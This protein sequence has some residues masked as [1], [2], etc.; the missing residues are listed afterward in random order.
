MFN[1]LSLKVKMILSFVGV[2]GL[3]AAQGMLNYQTTSDISDRFKEVVEVN[4]ARLNM[5]SKFTSV[6]AMAFAE[7]GIAGLNAD[8]QE[9]VKHL[10]TVSQLE[11]QL[12]ELD[13]EYRSSPFVDGEEKIYHEF[14]GAWRNWFEAFHK[15]RD[16]GKNSKT[17][18]DNKQFREVIVSSL[19]NKNDELRKVT[20]NL[21]SFHSHLA[22]KAE[23]AGLEE[24]RMARN[25]GILVIAFGMVSAVAIGFAFASFL[26]RRLSD[27]TNKIENSANSSRITGDDTTSAVRKLSENAKTAAS[28]LQ[29][30]VASLEEITSMVRTNTD[31][32]KEA[33]GLSQKSKDSAETGEKEIARLIESMTKIA[34]GSKKI[35]EIINVIDD[36][37]FQTNLLALNAAVEAARAGEQGKG[38]AVVAEAVRNLAQRSAVAARD[39]NS[40]IKENVANSQDGAKVAES[41]SVALAEIVLNVKK[42]SDLNNEI[43]LASQEQ[44]TG[45]EQIS[46]AMNQ[47]DSLTQST[48]ASAEEL[49]VSAES[50]QEQAK[51]FVSLAGNLKT[52]TFGQGA[53]ESDFSSNDRSLQVVQYSVEKK[54]HQERPGTQKKSVSNNTQLIS[55]TPVAPA[56][57]FNLKIPKFMDFKNLVKAES[58]PHSAEDSKIFKSDSVKQETKK[59]DKAA[60][61]KP[62]S[63]GQAK[64]TSKSHKSSAE[65]VSKMDAEKSP[66]KP[67][68]KFD[69]KFKKKDELKTET[70][71]EPKVLAPENVIPFETKKKPVSDLEAILPMEGDDPTRKVGSI[72]GF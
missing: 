70:Q 52:V 20:E 8:G 59:S 5:I 41:S 46:K 63:L 50:I 23:L 15:V 30:T 26:S 53:M 19:F 31:H 11:V 69:L 24:V 60:T 66:A 32:A 17:E 18:A 54:S 47:L 4:V 12:T 27:I 45:I 61:K 14:I 62:S 67:A 43:S 36:I 48:A 21:K 71:S 42:V 16:L 39:I 72:D 1:N 44:T 64:A 40:L 65:K 25:L 2:S 6:S 28:S 58:A 22:D 56:K 37:A 33:N 10:D 55:E 29:Q 49:N 3:L 35:E 34:E 57:L 68:K 51:S 9:T 38:F 7:L 13:K